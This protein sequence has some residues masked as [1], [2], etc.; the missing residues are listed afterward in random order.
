MVERPLGGV[1][2]SPM[3]WRVQPAWKSWAARLWR[4]G[5]ERE[6]RKSA[7]FLGIDCRRADLLGM[8]LLYHRRG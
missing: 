5:P 2:A 4:L 3:D 8:G 1:R 6:F 7:S